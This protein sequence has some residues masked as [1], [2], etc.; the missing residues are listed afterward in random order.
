MVIIDVTYNVKVI[1]HHNQYWFWKGDYITRSKVKWYKDSVFWIDL[2]VPF[3]IG[4]ISYV[5]FVSTTRQ[6]VNYSR[7]DLALFSVQA[8][9]S[10]MGIAILSLL[11]STTKESYLGLKI[12]TFFIEYQSRYFKSKRIIILQ[13]VLIIVDL[14]WISFCKPSLVPYVL[15]TSVILTI[16]QVISITGIFKS[17][18]KI[19]TEMEN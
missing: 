8:S 2:S 15:I 7:I 9:V 13:M 6:E 5:Y 18:E 16:R 17:H 4:F 12:S 10:V 1:L 11:A 14:F 3:F 19:A